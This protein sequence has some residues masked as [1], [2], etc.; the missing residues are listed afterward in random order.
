MWGYFPKSLM[1]AAVFLVCLC[2]AAI[3]KPQ[4]ADTTEANNADER[5]TPVTASILGPP[6]AAFMGADGMEHLVYELMLTNAKP[7]TATLQQVDVVDAASPARIL[8][9]FK[10]D[11]LLARL[12]T[13]QPRPAGS[14]TIELNGSRLFFIELTFEPGKVPAT[15]SHR[16]RLLGAANPGPTTPATALDYRVATFNPETGSL[17]ILAPP[18]EGSNWVALNGCC[19]SS[20]VHRGSFQ[21]VNGGLFDAQRF[22]IDY[23]Q[24]NAQG[25][26]V[27][28]DAADVRN[29]VGYS[30]NVLAVADGTVVSVLDELDD[31]VPGT[32]P[33]PTTITL[34]TVDGNHVVLDLGNGRYAFYAH[35]KKGSVRVRKGEKVTSGMVIGQLGNS[36]NT[37]APHLHFHV[38]NSASVLGSE[39][40]PYVIDGF[41][42]TGK[43]DVDAFETSET[44]E[45]KWGT[46]LDSDIEVTRA[47]PLNLDIVEFRQ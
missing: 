29:F 1:I 22:A 31:Q 26:F 13:L 46:A 47:F 4:K 28:G 9:T 35:L 14:A 36:G 33:D 23:M 42:L 12:R 41:K 34:G 15:I 25:E 8:A 10:E 18:L 40:M 37:S 44:L 45:G 20:I 24:L 38:V 21:T 2:G 30:A 16:L 27:H 3:A 19:N 32:L 6:P 39:G 7:A 17:P 5:F 43:V 11:D